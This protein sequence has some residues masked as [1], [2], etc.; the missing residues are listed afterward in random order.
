MNITLNHVHLKTPDPKKTARFYV[1]TLGATIVE[2]IQDR[3]YQLDLHG[4][5]VNLTTIVDEQ[6]R[7][8]H[9]GIEHIALDTDDLVKLV[10]DI[11]ANGGR[12]LEVVSD[13]DREVYF[14]EGPDGVQLE[15]SEIQKA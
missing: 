9:Y 14:A 11:T 2:V 8:Q 10:G 12:V 4:L 15:L 13:G 1:D 6:A 3:G 7:Q 5:R